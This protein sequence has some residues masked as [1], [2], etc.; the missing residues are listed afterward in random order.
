LDLYR[1]LLKDVPGGHP[2]L[3]DTDFDTGH[4]TKQGEY[5]LADQAYAKLLRDLAKKEFQ[6]VSP[7]LRANLLSFYKDPKPPAIVTGNSKKPDPKEWA[8]TLAALEKLRSLETPT[9]PPVPAA[10]SSP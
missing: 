8:E 7:D 6:G 3:P 1:S 5:S 10:V 9:Q 4:P 2:P